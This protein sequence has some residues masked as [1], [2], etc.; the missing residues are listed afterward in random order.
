MGAS[1]LGSS[2]ED[3]SAVAGE[4]KYFLSHAQANIL[5][6]AVFF[7]FAMAQRWSHLATLMLDDPIQHLDD[8]DS[9]AFI[10]T[11]RGCVSGTGGGR[12][13]VMSTCDHDLYILMLRK[14]GLL[15][16]EG[17]RV[18]GITLRDGGSDGPRVNYDFGGPPGRRLFA[19]AV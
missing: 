12:Q 1:N 15:E 9:V 5:A 7:A 3:L 10:D 4:P 2:T 19:A 16:Y 14:L 17:L 6:L 11:V 8:L 18:T 13:V